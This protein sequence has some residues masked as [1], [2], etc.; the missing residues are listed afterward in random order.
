[1]SFSVFVGQ[2]WGSVFGWDLFDF[3]DLPVFGLL[4]GAGVV[5]GF[6]EESAPSMLLVLPLLLLSLLRILLSAIKAHIKR[7][8]T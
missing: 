3:D 7:Y 5:L 4:L 6:T 8:N 2:Y 1:M